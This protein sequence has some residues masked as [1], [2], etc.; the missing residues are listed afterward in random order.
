M[1][2]VDA[3]DGRAWGPGELR[4]RAT[5]QEPFRAEPRAGPPGRPAASP[6]GLPPGPTPGAARFRAALAAHPSRRETAGL[7]DPVARGRAPPRSPRSREPGGAEEISSPSA[8][9]HLAQVPEGPLRAPPV[10]APLPAAS[11]T[12]GDRLLVGVGRQEARLQIAHGALAG[13]EIQL[14][15]VPGG[16]EAL[17]LTPGQCSRQTLASAMEEVARRLADRGI[18]WA[19]HVCHAVPHA[20][21]TDE[22][23]RFRAAAPGGVR[24]GGGGCDRPPLA[25]EGRRAGPGSGGVGRAVG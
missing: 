2:R 20:A 4:D 1:S 10:R 12:E 14:R 24:D 25:G 11:L 6:A 19:S 5:P 9:W 16:V 13:S 17:V 18:R 22:G 21:E 7:G 15:V 3:A 23:R 8:P